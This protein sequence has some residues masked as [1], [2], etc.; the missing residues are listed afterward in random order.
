M[1]RLYRALALFALIGVVEWKTL[2][3]KQ[4]LPLGPYFTATLREFSLAVLGVLVVLTLLAQWKQHLRERL[5]ARAADS[6][7]DDTPEG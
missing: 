6:Q 1:S 4:Q 7:R 3:G 2:D 5:E